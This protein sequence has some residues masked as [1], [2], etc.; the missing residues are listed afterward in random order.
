[1][2]H[3]VDDEAITRFVANHRPRFLMRAQQ[4]LAAPLFAEHVRHA[5][6]DARLTTLYGLLEAT[7]PPPFSLAELGAE[8]HTS[9]AAD[10][11]PDHA[12]RVLSYVSTVLD[13]PLPA[14]HRLPALGAAMH[15]AATRP[16]VLLVGDRALEQPA[17]ALAFRAA[18][19]LSFGWSGRTLS[20]ALPARQLR[21]LFFAAVLLVRPDAPL[22]DPDGSVAQLRD[23]FAQQPPEWRRQIATQI[24]QLLGPGRNQLNLHAFARGVARS[25]DRVGFLLCGDLVTAATIVRD[26]GADEAVGA[27]IDYAISETAGNARDALGLTVMV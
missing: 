17:I 26:E 3:G 27:L 15:M 7:L 4:P 25:A 22:D 6:D 11:L 1:M 19:A 13:V 10:R 23:R 14:I 20:S 18:R 2:V 21:R 16:G 24:D 12:R 8:A 9:I 5:D